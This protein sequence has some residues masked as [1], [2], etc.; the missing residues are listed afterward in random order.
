VAAYG[1]LSLVPIKAPGVSRGIVA[2]YGTLS[3]VPIKAPGVSRGIVAAYGTR[4]G[5]L[6]AISIPGDWS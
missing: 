1:T 4:G 5:R 3:L 6:E 2:A